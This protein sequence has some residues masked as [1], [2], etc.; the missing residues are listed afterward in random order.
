MKRMSLAVAALLIAAGSASADF[1]WVRVNVTQIAKIVDGLTSPGIGGGGP[2]MVGGGFKGGPGMIGGGFKGGPGMVGGPP[3]GMMIGGPPPGMMIGG[4]GMV[5]G[6]P[7]GAMI[8]GP[9]MV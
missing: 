7:P 5:G 3:P 9:G 6:P 1:I 8:G 4:A 2:G